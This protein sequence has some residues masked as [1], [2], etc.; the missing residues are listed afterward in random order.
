[1]DELTRKDLIEKAS[2]EAAKMVDQTD[3]LRLALIQLAKAF[4]L[5]AD[6]NYLETSLLCKTY[7]KKEDP[8]FA[9]ELGGKLSRPIAFGLP[10]ELTEDKLLILVA[11]TAMDC[12]EELELSRQAC[13]IISPGQVAYSSEFAEKALALYRNKLKEE[14]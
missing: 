14:Q 13:S 2:A 10:E 5:I 11:Q 4:E 12:L 7:F 1:M 9:E 8:E 6:T 3:Q